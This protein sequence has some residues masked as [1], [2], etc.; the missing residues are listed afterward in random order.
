MVNSNGIH[1][2]AI[3]RLLFRGPRRTGGLRFLPSPVSL[4]LCT[5]LWAPARHSRGKV[6]ASTC[7]GFFVLACCFI[8]TSSQP[9]RLGQ[10]CRL[11][12]QALRRSRRSQSTR[13][14]VKG[15]TAFLDAVG[16]SCFSPTNQPTN[17]RRCTCVPDCQRHAKFATHS[18]P[19]SSR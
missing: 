9:H 16:A 18:S 13:D 3:R 4:F 14:A 7:N 15:S 17:H 6:C 2:H 11:A 12:F 8:Y 10:R 1:A 5:R 19:T